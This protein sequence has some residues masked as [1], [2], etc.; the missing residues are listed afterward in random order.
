MKTLMLKGEKQT[1]NSHWLT[2]LIYMLLMKY[3]ED[4]LFHVVKPLFCTLGKSSLYIV[5]L[6]YFQ[7][8][9]LSGSHGL[10][11]GWNVLRLL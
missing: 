9:C 8:H 3:R 1:H 7:V 4:S 11:I 6:G 2:P 10:F 5:A